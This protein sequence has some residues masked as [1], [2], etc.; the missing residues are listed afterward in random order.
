MLL[1]R[2]TMNRRIG[3]TGLPL[4]YLAQLWTSAAVGAGAGWAIKRALPPMHPVF[5]AA[6][7]LIPYGLAFF[8]AAFLFGIPELASMM[9]FARRQATG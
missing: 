1:L 6:I 7:V 9:R 8:G 2:R 5:T 3:V 4:T